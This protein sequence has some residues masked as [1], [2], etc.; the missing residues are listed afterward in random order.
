MFMRRDLPMATMPGF[1][2]RSPAVPS[3]HRMSVDDFHRIGEAGILGHDARVELI[4]GE[5]IDMSPI[6][7]LHAAMVACLSA[8]FHDSLKKA[9]VVWVQNPI[10]LDE[11]N[12]P[13][14]DIAL[15]V[16]RDDFYVMRSP[17]VADVMLVVEVADTN[18]DHDLRVKV[19][20]YA[21]AG[22]PEVW[23]IDVITRTTHRFRCPKDVS[24]ADHDTID[25]DSLLVFGS[26]SIC[27]GTLLP[28][29]S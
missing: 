28:S 25:P 3:R 26:A 27:L 1:T 12:E 15:L 20:R 19:P 21:A 23:V 5:I 11:T 17:Q 9:A 10:V 6:G 16:P 4:D 14:P 7:R 2:S 18:L 29:M 13:L 8:A 24:Y 22:V